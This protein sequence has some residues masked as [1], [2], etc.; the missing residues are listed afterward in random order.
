MPRFWTS[1]RLGSGQG[2]AEF[3]GAST[4]P[5]PRGGGHTRQVTP[6]DA[7]CPKAGET[8][9]PVSKG[10]QLSDVIF[11]F[12]YFFFK[13]L[14]VMQVTRECILVT[15]NS[16]SLY[17]YRQTPLLPR[18][19][20]CSLFSFSS[21]F[22]AFAH[23]HVQ[24]QGQGFFSENNDRRCFSRVFFFPDDG[25]GTRPQRQCPHSSVFL[26]KSHETL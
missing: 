17:T 24:I 14:K 19:N 20:R 10:S 1:A 22:G 25:P 8:Y 21:R 13:N 26:V 3:T 23:L 16:G 12:S 18:V 5:W 4:R 7:G 9:F 15:E 2:P 11:G 6:G